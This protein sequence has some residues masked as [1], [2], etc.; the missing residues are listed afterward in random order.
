[1][2]F[3]KLARTDLNLLV[4][5]YILLDEQSVS[6]TA[7]RLFLTQPAISKSLLRLREMFDD[8]LFTRSGRGLI[9][10]PHAV[11]LKKP[12]ENILFDVDSIFSAEEFNP[13]SYQG[14]F[15]F[16]VNEFLDM[17]LIPSLIAEIS[18]SAPGIH[19]NTLTQ[20]NDQLIGLEKGELDFVLNLQFSEIPKGF[21]SDVIMQDTPQIFA[22]LG[23]PLMKKKALKLA[24]VMDYPMVSLIIPDMDKIGLFKNRVASSETDR[25]WEI[26]FVTEN[27]ITAIATTSKT[28]YL[29]PGPGLMS[30]FT[31]KQRAVRALDMRSEFNL[32]KID[33]CLIYHDR[34]NNS[35]AHQW[36]RNKIMGIAKNL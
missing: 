25:N 23:H 29:L 14:V 28:D 10:T 24:D 7:D 4:T 18:N 15:N 34:V 2:D 17:A 26:S 8:P 36:L 12:L 27:L 11:A 19:I 6:K 32:G 20:I 35:L 22:R 9:A 33:Y 5:L 21:H 16:A 3:R 1:M 30:D 31:S 13:S